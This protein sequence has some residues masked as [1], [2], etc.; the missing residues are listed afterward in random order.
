MKGNKFIIFLTLKKSSGQNKNDEKNHNST[1]MMGD[2]RRWTELNVQ[3]LTE[4][5]DAKHYEQYLN[6]LDEN[7]LGSNE[8]EIKLTEENC[9]LPTGSAALNYGL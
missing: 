2:E 6:L 7:N 8:Y 4:E 1:G 9:Q 5:D 3:L